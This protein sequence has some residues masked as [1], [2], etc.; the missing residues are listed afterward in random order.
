MKKNNEKVIGEKE[1][2]I[3]EESAAHY[4]IIREIQIIRSFYT[5]G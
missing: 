4:F 3:Y 1:L 2:A 5:L